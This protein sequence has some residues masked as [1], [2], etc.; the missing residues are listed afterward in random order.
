MGFSYH[1]YGKIHTGGFFDNGHGFVENTAQL[2]QDSV[3]N[4]EIALKTPCKILDK[5]FIQ[6]R[7][8]IE[9][10]ATIRGNARILGPKT[11]E[12]NRYLAQSPVIHIKDHAVIEDNAV[13]DVRELTQYPS[14][15]VVIGG[16][17]VIGGNSV[18]KKNTYIIDN[19]R[20]RKN[21]VV[22]NTALDGY[23]SRPYQPQNPQFNT[24]D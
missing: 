22:E 20:V 10:A 12:S 3:K 11:D 18:I 17:A 21:A 23:D 13:I 24:L 2:D 7:V 6:G 15:A 8:K 16:Y 5:A 4:N 9:G 1:F 14:E 19:A